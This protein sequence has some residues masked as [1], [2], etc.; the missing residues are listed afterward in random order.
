MVPGFSLKHGVSWLPFPVY[1]WAE[2]SIHPILTSIPLVYHT[3]NWRAFFK[4]Q[5]S[6]QSYFPPPNPLLT[7]TSSSNITGLTLGLIVNTLTSQG[8]VLLLLD[9][10]RE[11]WHLNYLSVQSLCLCLHLFFFA[12]KISKLLIMTGHCVT[13]LWT[14]L[15]FKCMA[16][17]RGMAQSEKAWLTSR[18]T[19]VQSLGLPWWKERADFHICSIWTNMNTH[20][21]TNK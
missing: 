13:K 6:M 14:K 2:Y 11:T 5:Y 3:S 10:P 19:W 21:K 12:S 9:T 4:P 8:N 16:G 17:F 7:T 15:S 18:V 20:R 1:T